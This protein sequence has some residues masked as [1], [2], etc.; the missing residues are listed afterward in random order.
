MSHNT[1]ASERHRHQGEQDRDQSPN[2]AQDLVFNDETCRALR[3]NARIT[4]RA[5]AV[6]G[7][8][9]IAEIAL[10]A[11]S[12]VSLPPLAGI[13]L[14]VA[15]AIGGSAATVAVMKRVNLVPTRETPREM[16]RD[17]TH[18]VRVIAGNPEAIEARIEETSEPTARPEL[19][20]GL[21]PMACFIAFGLPL[22]L[23]YVALGEVSGTTIIFCIAGCAALSGVL[24]VFAKH[25]QPNTYP[26]ENPP[27]NEMVEG[28]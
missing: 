22:M 26:P 2:S 16:K 4:G 8:F 6:V 5:G 28:K 3:Q 12:A 15:G 24:F 19:A 9:L 17:L 7:T 13:I 11:L 27:T 18:E 25:E 14:K 21:C 23:L 20:V 1:T 10:I